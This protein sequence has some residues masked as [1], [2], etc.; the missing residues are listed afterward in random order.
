MQHV[1]T[2]TQGISQQPPAH[3]PGAVP[4]HSAAVLRGQPSQE[5]RK[6]RGKQSHLQLDKEEGMQPAGEH[7]LSHCRPPKDSALNWKEASPALV[8]FQDS[9]PHRRSRGKANCCHRV[10]TVTTTAATITRAARISSAVPLCSQTTPRDVLQP[11]RWH[12]K[13]QVSPTAPAQRRA[14]STLTH[15]PS[16]KGGPV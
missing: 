2:H 5:H 15:Y 3:S 7:L 8:I 12:P 10:L 1:S 13:G 14:G 16:H 11:Y 4:Q 9:S 6:R